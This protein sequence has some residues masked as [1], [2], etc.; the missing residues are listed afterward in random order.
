MKATKLMRLLVLFL[1]SAGAF[2]ALSNQA[3]KADTSCLIGYMSCTAD[4]ESFYPGTP[5]YNRCMDKCLATELACYSYQ[6]WQDWL[7]Q[8]NGNINNDPAMID[9]GPDPICAIYPDIIRG[10]GDLPTAE[11]IEVCVIMAQQEQARFHCP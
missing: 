6:G 3:V 2:F 1:L 8:Y 4:C 7:I 5:E 10:C 11:E 9:N